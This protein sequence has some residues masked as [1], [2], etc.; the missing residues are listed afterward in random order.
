MMRRTPKSKTFTRMW[1]MRFDLT[2]AS[3]HGLPGGSLLAE[4]SDPLLHD[5]LLLRVL[6][7]ICTEVSQGLAWHAMA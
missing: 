6:C 5:L 1:R 2:K 7:S 3:S 4:Y